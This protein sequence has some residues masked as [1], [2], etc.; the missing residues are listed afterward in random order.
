MVSQQLD[1]PIRE[2]FPDG[3][4]FVTIEKKKHQGQG[5]LTGPTG[6]FTGT[7][8]KGRFK[9][10]NCARPLAVGCFVFS[11]EVMAISFKRL[12]TFSK[13]E[14]A[15]LFQRTGIRCQLQETFIRPG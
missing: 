5:M 7:T 15:G 8:K 2:L 1:C 12:P 11:P 9:P 13:E 4:Y 6:A 3:P 10:Y 14:A